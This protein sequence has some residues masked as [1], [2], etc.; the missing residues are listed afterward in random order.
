MSQV[1][2]SRRERVWG[3]VEGDGYVQGREGSREVNA[4]KEMSCIPPI[5]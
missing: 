1:N 5:L 3:G 4:G 2:D